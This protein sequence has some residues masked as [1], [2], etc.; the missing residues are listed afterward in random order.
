MS[1]VAEICGAALAFLV[2]TRWNRGASEFQAG[3][4]NCG[5]VLMGRNPGALVNLRIAGAWMFVCQ[6][7]EFT[8]FH[9]S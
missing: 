6:N 2:R 5:R 9:R 8:D 3:R 7:M 1:K 4:S